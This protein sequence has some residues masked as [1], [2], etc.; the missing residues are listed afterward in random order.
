MRPVSSLP[1]R[2]FL[3]MGLYKMRPFMKNE[4]FGSRFQCSCGR[5]HEITPREIL[6]S[7]D[8]ILQLPNLVRKLNLGNR[9][10]IVMDRR[11]REAAGDN[12]A[13]VLKDEGFDVRIHVIPDRLGGKWPVTDDDTV[14]ALKGDITSDWLLSVG[15]GVLNDLAKWA[16]ADLGLPY[17][18]FATAASMNGYSSANVA[19]TIQNVKSLWRGR[20][21]LAVLSDPAVLANAPYALTT[22]GLGDVLAK[23]ISTTDWR[24]NHLLFGDYYCETSA[25]LIT[26]IEPLYMESPEDVPAGKPETLEALFMALVLSGVSMTM[27]ES[28]SPASGGEHLVSH[29]L[30]T[31]SD[32]DG[33]PHDLHGRQVGLATVLMAELYQ[34]VFAVDEPACAAPP[35]DVDRAFWGPISDKVQKLYADKLGRISDAAGTLSNADS[36]DDLRQQL[37]V[38]L[39]KPERL[40]DCLVRAKAAY[41]AEDLGMNKDRLLTALTHA[42]EFRARFTILDLARLVG[43]WPGAAA[44]IV[45]QWA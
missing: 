39:H 15:S 16:G 35:E 4:L 41:R 22:A 24:L 19:A 14:E 32:L 25:G 23:T 37:A 3:L 5:T 44:E 36:W 40:R 17:V 2:P 18:S 7:E 21:P 20:P 12:V 28:S 10:G 31:M 45:E 34:R 11:T 30:D 9:L 6:Y 1:G 26:E 8:A 33:E 42:H 43:I 38:R 13:D 29:T 27:A